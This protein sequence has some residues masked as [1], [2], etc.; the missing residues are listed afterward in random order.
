MAYDTT[1]S[2]LIGT[3]HRPMGGP[4]TV[5]ASHALL[6]EE[7]S[8]ARWRLVDLRGGDVV[9]AGAKTPDNLLAQGLLLFLASRDE[10]PA[11]AANP[12]LEPLAG[13]SA[14]GTR[15]STR[16]P[17]A[18]VHDVLEAWPA[19]LGLIVTRLPGTSIGDEDVARLIERAVWV[20]EPAGVT[21]PGA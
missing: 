18:A 12:R 6:L 3:V 15:F 4:G 7:G 19:D 20:K 9:V 10:A 8:R 14:D 5:L 13:R 2:V 16:M 11:L 1:A 21:V 17:H